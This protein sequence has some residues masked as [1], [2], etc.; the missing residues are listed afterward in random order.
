MRFVTLRSA[1]S[2]ASVVMVLVTFALS[3][4]ASANWVSAA[5]GSATARADAIATPTGLSASCNLL[6]DKSVTLSWSSTK[7]WADYEVRW[8]TSPGGPYGT[9][10][11]TTST[12]YTT[13]ALSGSLLGTSYYFVVRAVKGSWLSANSNQVTRS[14]ALLTCS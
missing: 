6:L 7:A 13:P 14:I 3:D 9:S 10:A 8:G 1:S 5:S 4:P 2:I 11:T 12:T